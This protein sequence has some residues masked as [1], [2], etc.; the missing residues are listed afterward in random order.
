MRY[1]SD[2]PE[3][4]KGLYR[5]QYGYQSVQIPIKALQA[6]DTKSSRRIGCYLPAGI[7]GPGYT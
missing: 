3:I 1:N 2:R 4:V 6:V 5:M 7:A